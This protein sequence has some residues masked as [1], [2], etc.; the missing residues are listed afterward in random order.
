MYSVI[1]AIRILTQADEVYTHLSLQKTN[2]FY[3]TEQ[4]DITFLYNIQA[5]HT[6]N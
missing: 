3:V 4:N 5:T 1:T 2:A 6:N